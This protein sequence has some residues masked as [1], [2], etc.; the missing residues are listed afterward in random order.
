MRP[1]PE[2]ALSVTATARF[3]PEGEIEVDWDGVGTF[4]LFISSGAIGVAVVML[5]AYQA[6]LTSKLE[7]E[8]LR[9]AAA[10]PVD[11][12][13][14]GQIHDLE[15]QVRRLTERVDFSERLL[16]D[17]HAPTKTDDNS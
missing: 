9:S 2:V 15:V 11:H 12:Q 14:E 4:A 3:T 5:R 13:I 6:R 1:S 16:S 7:T 10:A 8:R 17:R